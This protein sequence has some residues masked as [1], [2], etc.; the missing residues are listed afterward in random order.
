MPDTSP[1]L[2]L[3]I[4]PNGVRAV[5]DGSWSGWLMRSGTT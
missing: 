2:T 3:Q 4:T 5:L 1:T